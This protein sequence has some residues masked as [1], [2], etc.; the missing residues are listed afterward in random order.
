MI[1]KGGSRAGPNQLARHLQ[2]TDTNERVEILELHSPTGSLKEAFRDWQFLA[3]GT[4]GTKGLYHANIDP[5]AK[6]TMTPEQ[7][8]RA[9]DV[10]EEELGFQG[11]PRAVVMHDKEGR[12]HIHVVWQRADIETMTL[13]AD[14]HNYRKHELASQR[15]EQEF[16]HEFVPGKHAKR[17]REHN[18]ELPKSEI[19]HAEWQQ[20]ERAGL[21]PRAR[22]EFITQLFEQSDSGTAFK[23]ALEQGG[24]VLAQGDRRDF[25][26]IDQAGEIH[27]LGRQIK[28]VKAKELREFMADVDRDR[29]P[30]VEEARERATTLQQQQPAPEQASPASEQAP[31]VSDAKPAEPTAIEKAL[32]ERHAAETE[33]LRAAQQQERARTAEIIGADIRQKMEHFDAAQQAAR[34]RYLRE[35]DKRG[36]DA[37]LATLKELFMPAKVAEEALREQERAEAFL[38]RLETERRDYTERL[39]REKAEEL[40]AL[41]ER[42]GQQRREHD[43]SRDEDLARYLR[44]E[45]NARRLQAE[46]ED[47]A[48]TRKEERARD[49]PEPG[50]PR[51]R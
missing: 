40:D 50:P 38:D 13:K 31:Q 44:E 18:P 1:I 22:K 6:Y 49:G 48:R 25:V 33:K 10:L 7:W 29:L 37:V 19:N 12:Q 39:E 36:I 4:R 28:D 23:A 45:E 14:S 26:I 9:V 21:D 11:Q 32:T 24:Y 15:L 47:R 8:K 16:G 2:R 35:N 34:D 43:A 17:D 41:D 3:T 42:H 46:M 30:T 51:A 27:S 5:D 20:G